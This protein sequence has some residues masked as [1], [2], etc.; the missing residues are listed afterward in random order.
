LMHALTLE[1]RGIFLEGVRLVRNESNVIKRR[2]AQPLG[3]SQERAMVV[4]IDHAKLGE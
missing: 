3:K 4:P 1:G 2:F